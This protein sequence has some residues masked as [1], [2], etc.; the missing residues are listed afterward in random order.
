MKQKIKKLIKES[1]IE[2]LITYP[3]IQTLIISSFILGF[4]IYIKINEKFS[5]IHLLFS[6]IIVLLTCYFFQEILKKYSLIQDIVII[7]LYNLLI[8]FLFHVCNLYPEFSI[9]NLIFLMY[10]LFIVSLFSFA[11]FKFK[12]TKPKK[13]KVKRART[14]SRRIRR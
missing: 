2:S 9:D 14:S 4:S 3:I 1:F 11:I 10:L 5:N 12:K 7:I 13:S 8:Y 6:F